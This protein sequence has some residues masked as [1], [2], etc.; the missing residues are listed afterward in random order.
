MIYYVEGNLFETPAQTLVNTVNTVG[1]MGKGIAKQFKTIF[2]EMFQQYRDLCEKGE[3]KIGQLWLYKTPHKWI[4]NFPTKKDWR[5][6]SRIEYIED[7]LK[8]FQETSSILGIHS[9]AF[10]ALGC[11]NGELGWENTVRPLMEKYL[12]RLP[13]D[14]FI[15]P[16]KPSGEEPEHKKVQEIKRWLLHEPQA[17][18][19]TEVWKDLEGILK[20]KKDFK[21]LSQGIHFTASLSSDPPG[22]KIHDRKSFISQE[23]LLNIWK[24]IRSYGFTARPLVP[25]G[26]DKDI[27]YLAPILAELEYIQA[28]PI[29][30]SY[31][32]LV[33][34]AAIGLQYKAPSQESHGN[35]D[36]FVDQ[37]TRLG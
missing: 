17:L 24:Q 31:Q 9:V 36:L 35:L 33:G 5:H 25:G 4:L 18:P 8:K 10:P 1:V 6:P 21:T 22:I 2:P 28:V 12:S 16:H 13:I 26:L 19:F 29:S 11:G 20:S 7:G 37:V 32:G 15:Y 23:A 30:Q 34:N 14:V 27:S 3:F